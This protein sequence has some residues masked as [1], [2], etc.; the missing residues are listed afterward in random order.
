M[1]GGVPFLPAPSSLGRMRR[2]A[3]IGIDGR[4]GGVGGVIV[5]A[6]VDLHRQ[7]C[8]GERGGHDDGCW[9]EGKGRGEARHHNRRRC[10]RRCR[11]VRA[12]MLGREV[13]GGALMMIAGWEVVSLLLSATGKVLGEMMAGGLRRQ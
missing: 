13:G 6:V 11:A 10:R 4:R 2:G 3:V 9:W 1:T 8:G 5:A 12:M 7:R